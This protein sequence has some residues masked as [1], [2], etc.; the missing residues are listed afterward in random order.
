MRRSG[1]ELARRH[2]G[3]NGWSHLATLGRNTD[4]SGAD[5]TDPLAL[6]PMTTEKADS[7]AAHG[8]WQHIQGELD[9]AAE[10]LQLDEGMHRVL[11]VAKREL[12]VNFPVTH[13]D[14]H[15]EVYTGYRVHHNVNR[16]PASG[17][18]RYVPGL[19]LDEVRALAMLNTWK[20]ALVQIPFGGAAGGVRVNPR[21]LSQ[22]ER[23]G[24]TRR[25]ATEISPLIGKDSDIPAP[26]VNTGS[27]TMAWIMDTISMH[28]GY[29][30]AASVIG[31]P[32]AVGG[33]LGRRSATGRGALRCVM[34]EASALGL[35]LQGARI[36]IQGFGRV[37][38]TVAEELCQA[39]AVVVAIAD[40]RDAVANPSGI[41]IESATEWM[42]EHDAISGLPE[43][44]AI[45]KAD[46]FGLDCD[47]L[48]LAGLQA[49][50]TDANATT[51]R[52]RI[53]AEVA[54]GGTTPGA[55]RVLEDRGISV[56]PDIICTAG[57][58]VLGY[59][60]WVQDMQAFFWT[61]REITDQLDRIVDEAMAGIRAMADAEKVDLR[62][63][64]MMVAVSRVAE[65]TTLRGLY[66]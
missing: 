3:L 41:P 44:E 4:V 32:L 51:I 2:I 56:I 66:P 9:E 64:A 50:V 61:E 36:V 23:Q 19:D 24:L 46:V 12:T 58:T 26:D 35:D 39:G 7:T 21:K 28:R 40:D 5:R 48:V 37:G 54:N 11:R 45:A 31:K 65:A 55:D 52:A 60:E 47:I 17:G 16:G 29:T 14:G 34:A 8:L 30:V 62:T 22:Q 49:E 42:R 57:G 25:Y 15:V 53:V 59:F 63:A 10:K 18:I 1:F 43:A 27:Q 6:S 33:T 38:M 20:A 13:D